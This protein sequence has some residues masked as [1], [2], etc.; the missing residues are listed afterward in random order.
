MKNE[1][2]SFRWKQGLCAAAAT[3]MLILSGCAGTEQPVP[4]TTEP[5]ATESAAPQTAATK[6]SAT[7]T[8]TPTKTEALNEATGEDLNPEFTEQYEDPHA[9]SKPA[10]NGGSGGSSSN[11]YGTLLDSGSC[12]EHLNWS[13]RQID[14]EHVALEFSGSG[15]MDHYDE[16]G[17]RAP[18][19]EYHDRITSISTSDYSDT[20]CKI[21]AIGSYAFCD[22][23]ALEECY[24][25][26]TITEI[27]EGAFK[28]CTALWQVERNYAVTS[29]GDKAFYGCS[30]LTWFPLPDG[31][32]HIGSE[33]FAGTGI[34]QVHFLKTDVSIGDKAFPKTTVICGWPGSTAEN[35]AESSGSPFESMEEIDRERLISILKDSKELQ[36]TDVELN[37]EEPVNPMALYHPVVFSNGIYAMDDGK[38]LMKLVYIPIVTVPEQE[39]EQML[40]QARQTG[41]MTALGEEW[42]FTDSKETA[43]VGIDDAFF[44]ESDYGWIFNEESHFGY[45]IARRDDVFV[46]EYSTFGIPSIAMDDWENEISLGWITLDGDTPVTMWRERNEY[47]QDMEHYGCNPNRSEWYYWQLELDDDGGFVVNA[48][49][50]GKK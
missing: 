46:F 9:E 29:V 19:Y 11:G 37:P 34:D 20:S 35:Y 41:R 43:K 13:V 5:A 38:Y 18:W 4:A 21:S 48:N 30:A 17:N 10:G 27:G 12:G 23:T 33:A 42:S 49:L 39:M 44:A 24:L 1:T 32:E 40:A 31:L 15:A 50:A 47:I 16:A 3:L 45:A 22:F 2:N 36:K 6:E 28:G 8:S 14:S 7:V 26:R 25:L